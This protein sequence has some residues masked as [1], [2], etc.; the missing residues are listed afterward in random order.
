MK[1]IFAFIVLASLIVVLTGCGSANTDNGQNDNVAQDNVNTGQ[2]SDNV[3]SV[4]VNANR[5]TEEI[6]NDIKAAQEAFNNLLSAIKNI[7]M[8]T[9]GKYL[10]TGTLTDV[11]VDSVEGGDEVTEAVFSNLESEIV[12]GAANPDGS[13]TIIA[14]LTTIDLTGVLGQCTVLVM[15]ELSEKE[16][17]DEQLDAR[18]EEVFREEVKKEGLPKVTNQVDVK[19][20]KTEAGWKV[21]MNDAFQNA[22][23]GGFLSS[24][25]K[26]TQSMNN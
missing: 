18:I 26:A 6:E 8:E 19:V 14:D 2:G 7:D 1:R 23:S 4:N 13:V 11:N 3:G 15:N 9:A 16:L 5:S 24:L 22:I 20:K 12:T 10:D 25:A 17:S 21:E